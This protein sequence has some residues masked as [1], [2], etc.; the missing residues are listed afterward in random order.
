MTFA[1]ACSVGD[2][3]PAGALQVE[4]DDTSGAPRPVAAGRRRAVGVVALT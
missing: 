2:V 4:L 3:E 1:R